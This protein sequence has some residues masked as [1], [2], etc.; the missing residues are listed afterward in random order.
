MQ[1]FPSVERG[2]K[3]TVGG[4]P[5]CDF[6]LTPKSNTRDVSLRTTSVNTHVDKGTIMTSAPI[7]ITCALSA[8]LW[9]WD[10]NECLHQNITAK[11]D[12]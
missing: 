2:H 9:W 11:D 12:S 10:R 8:L 4:E 1:S 3:A 7:M 5:E 6:S